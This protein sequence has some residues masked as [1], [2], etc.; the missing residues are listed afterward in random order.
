MFESWKLSELE[1]IRRQKE[2]LVN[3]NKTELVVRILA[4]RSTHRPQVECQQL[5]KH[6]SSYFLWSALRIAHRL[7]ALTGP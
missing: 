2:M 3:F 4:V 7:R 1:S 6:V 5:V